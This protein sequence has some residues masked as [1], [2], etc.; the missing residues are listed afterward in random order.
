[1][2]GDPFA[3]RD[4]VLQGFLQNAQLAALVGCML[5]SACC[6]QA[7]RTTELAFNGI[8][9]DPF[10]PDGYSSMRKVPPHLQPPT[11]NIPPSTPHTQHAL[12]TLSHLYNESRVCGDEDKNQTTCKGIL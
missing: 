6:M 10:H 2:P 9:Y 4:V 7:Q 12:T 5:T 11:P 1:M 8:N 3:G